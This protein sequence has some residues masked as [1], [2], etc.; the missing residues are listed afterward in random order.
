[1]PER[2]LAEYGSAEAAAAAI[3]ALR[4]RG[5]LQI[6]AYLP[7]P[8]HEVEDALARPRSRLPIGIFVIGT[9]A[10]LGAYLLQWLLVGYLY[11]LIVGYGGASRFGGG[12][13]VMF[14]ATWDTPL[15]SRPW[16]AAQ[17]MS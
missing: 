12:R 13:S 1:M 15:A 11:P 7:F 16:Q 17:K 14:S 4:E 2:V 5:H 6:E 10:A 8:S 9:S 3:R